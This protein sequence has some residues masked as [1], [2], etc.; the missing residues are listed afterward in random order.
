[1][2][3]ICLSQIFEF[4]EFFFSLLLYIIKL[5]Y[6]VYIV[7]GVCVSI[8]D[9]H[10]DVVLPTLPTSHD[11]RSTGGGGATNGHTAAV[12]QTACFEVYARRSALLRWWPR[13]LHAHCGGRRQNGRCQQQRQRQHPG[14]AFQTR[15]DVCKDCLCFEII[16]RRATTKCFR[17]RTK[18]GQTESY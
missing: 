4:H 11:R 2:T 3:C 18:K 1:M 13:L 6:A 9:W 12:L 14:C 5:H 8:R 10:F 16:E 17:K 15:L 7:S